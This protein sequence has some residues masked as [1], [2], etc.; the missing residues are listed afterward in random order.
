MCTVLAAPR[1]V[2]AGLIAPPMVRGGR[3]IAHTDTFAGRVTPPH[4]TQR[5]MEVLALAAE[6]FGNKRIAAHLIISERTVKSHLTN[7]M[8]K[9]S[10]Y[11]RTHAVVIALRAGWLSI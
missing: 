5:E 1:P 9:L 3:S 4:L 11:D 7:I 10:A 2:A 8:V 6:G